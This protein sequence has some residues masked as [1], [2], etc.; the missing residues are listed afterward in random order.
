MKPE[1]NCVVSLLTSLISLSEFSVN[2]RLDANKRVN[3]FSFWH[4]A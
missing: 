2:F 1:T 3:V 4:K